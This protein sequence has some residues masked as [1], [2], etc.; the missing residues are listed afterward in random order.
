MLFLQEQFQDMCY[1]VLE[2]VCW[3]RLVMSMSKHD[4]AMPVV[5]DGSLL[6]KRNGQVYW[7]TVGT[8]A[9]Y[10]W[11]S[12]ATTF[13]FR[14]E[15]G[16]FTARKEQ[17]GHKR[18]GWYWRA[19]RRREGRLHRAYLGTSEEVTLDRLRTIAA[20]LSVQDTLSGSE[21][22]AHQGVFQGRP[23]HQDQSRRSP[24]GTLGQPVEGG[25]ASENVKRSASI[26]PVPLTSLIGR[27]REVAA[28][29]TLLV[30][31]EVRL[32]TLT[33]TGGV[34]KTRLALEIAT[35]VQGGFAD[36]VCFVSLAPFQDTELVLPTALQALGLQGSTEPPLEQ[37][38]AALRARHL[39]LVLDNFE[40]LLAAAPRL[41]ELL[42]AC[43]RL[44]LLVTSREM[45]HV[46]G[47]RV[48]PVPSLALPDLKHLPDC[49]TLS[50]YG[51]VA[52]FLER[53]QEAQPSFPLTADTAPLIAEICVRLDG[54][55]LALELAAARLKLL[56]L[57]ALLERLEHRL[58]VLTGGPRD[59]PARQHTLHNTLAWSY[60]LL[61]EQE[62]RLFR[63]LSVFVGGCTLEAVELISGV[64][65][66]MSAQVL[67]EVTSLLDKHLLCQIQQGSAEQ[68]DRRLVMLETIREFGLECLSTSGEMKAAR[69]VHAEYYLRLVE[70]AEPHLFGADQERWFARLEQE[71]DNLRAALA[72]A[73]E[74]R[75]SGQRMEAA[76][77]LSGA[78]ERFWEVRGYL[79]EGRKWLEQALMSSEG[80]QLSIR[81]RAFRAAGWLALLQGDFDQAEA[82]CQ[83]A[84]QQYR[85]ARDTR[86]MAWSLHRLGRVA[87]MKNDP[88][89]ASSRFEESLAL[90]RQVS[91]QAGLAY[92]LQVMG[93]VAIEQGEPARARLLLEESLALFRESGDKGGMAWSLYYLGRVFLEQGEAVRVS[94]P[95]EDRSP[96]ERARD[97]KAEHATASGPPE[98]VPL[99]QGGYARA[100]ALFEES[101]VLFREVGSKWGMAFSLLRLAQ[102]RFVT[103]IEQATVSSL[104]EESLAFF[105]EVG[106]KAGLARCLSLAGQ[107]AL[108]RG[109]AGRARAYAKESLRL[110]REMGYQTATVES[111]AVLARVA[112]TEG[113]VREAYTLFE[114]SLMLARNVSDKGMLAFCLEGMASFLVTQSAEKR[115]LQTGRSQE[116]GREGIL[117]A[118]RLW[119]AAEGL[120]ESAGTPLSPIERAD[121]ERTVATAR[122]LLGE[123]SFAQ[124]WDEGRMVTPEQAIAA[125]G[126][127]LIPDRTPTK[128]RTTKHKNPAS[129]YPN[130]L[131][132]REVEVLRLVAQGL[133]DAEVAEILVIS[134]RTVNAHLRSIYSKLN[135]TSRTA[136]TYFAIEHHLI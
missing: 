121:Y 136:S 35:E 102:V 69:Q 37:L 126:Q 78:L 81:A 42:A 106:Q 19:Y 89:L 28:A 7:L 61:S 50:R 56:S 14:C 97:H 26:L 87:F 38:K 125:R 46:R 135:I 116:A 68:D 112:A 3:T 36:G 99:H 4:E 16:T 96:R 64:L 74:Q 30:R 117:W 52:L 53:A 98:Q 20:R 66:S 114:E 79:S 39:L 88:V 70:E 110:S 93:H 67:D 73:V 54:L 76:L 65:G 9:W 100:Y 111:L 103:Q 5:Q 33:G 23:G 31:P 45:L 29:C 77:R 17:A 124:A 6:Y 127:T 101:L 108:S 120:R 15:V 84:L 119:G 132:E 25:E 57:Q 13:A 118:A 41:L 27:Q 44:K 131:T 83:Q 49:E 130:D 80:G 60:E 86:G 94:S 62:Q 107:V 82:L 109:D 1:T 43:S 47:E 8:P 48:F 71:Y 113:D 123:Q 95:L 58:T 90:F 32:L 105:R 24:T 115:I 59:L 10:A 129:L 75:E 92:I 133:S 21:Q 55:P 2:P 12:M 134:P 22:E 104:L 122:T 18:G 34:G 11:L 51:A 91:D 63:L 72:W 128:A 40:R 85:E